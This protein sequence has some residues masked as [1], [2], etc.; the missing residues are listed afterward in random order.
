MQLLAGGMEP[1]IQAKGGI[2]GITLGLNRV[3]LL[4]ISWELVLMGGLERPV[5]ECLAISLKCCTNKFLDMNCSCACPRF[6]SVG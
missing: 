2:A 6:V 5:T 4:P 3:Q 1:L